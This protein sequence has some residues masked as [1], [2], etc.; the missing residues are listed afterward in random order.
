MNEESKATIELRVNGQ[1]VGIVSSIEYT[2]PAQELPPIDNYARFAPGNE[3][4][5]EVQLTEP[6]SLQE[7]WRLLNENERAQEGDSRWSPTL[8]TWLSIT[9]QDLFPTFTQYHIVRRKA[10]VFV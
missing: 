1:F 4:T 6:V 8:L 7:G 10:L 5:I 3:I 9:K 2:R